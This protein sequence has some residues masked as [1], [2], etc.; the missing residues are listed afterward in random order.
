MTRVANENIEEHDDNIEEW[1]SI[2]KEFKV[3]RRL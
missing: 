3:L 1:R 2:L